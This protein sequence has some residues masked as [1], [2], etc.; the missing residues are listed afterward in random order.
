M[1]ENNINS[2]NTNF[3]P[4]SMITEF[5]GEDSFSS[6]SNSN[7]D[8]DEEIHKYGIKK[9]FSKS[10]KN[11]YEI[12]LLLFL[13]IIL[14]IIFLLLMFWI[15]YLK[16]KISLKNEEIKILE[17]ENFYAGRIKKETE[18][19]LSKIEDK[20][21]KLI[22]EFIQLHKKNNELSEEL[23]KINKEKTKEKNDHQEK[24]KKIENELKAQDLEKKLNE[25]KRRREIYPTRHCI[26]F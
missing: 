25:N 16:R 22:Y 12:I 21:D 4:L 14:I 23:E 10:K 26:I 17:L 8:E 18:D 9:N 5:I 11:K 13:G 19:E 7:I 3:S 2:K 15:F 1:E 24:I 20:Y 6:T